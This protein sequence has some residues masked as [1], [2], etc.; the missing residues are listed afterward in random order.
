M[1]FQDITSFI[2]V[3]III[4][5]HAL[6]I[7]STYLKSNQLLKPQF[8]SILSKRVEGG[9]NWQLT[10]CIMKW[11]G[12]YAT[13]GWMS[14]SHPTNTL[15]LE[16]RDQ[17]CYLDKTFVTVYWCNILTWQPAQGHIQN[18]NQNKVVVITVMNVEFIQILMP[19]EQY[20]CTSSWT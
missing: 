3:C 1:Q 17:Q 4:H 13:Q 12:N 5:R 9:M 10:V 8:I 14:L 18:L 16:R 6:I 20:G 2:F 7:L 11:W 19:I 15:L